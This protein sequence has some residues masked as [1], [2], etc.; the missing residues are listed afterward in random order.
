[1]DDLV[2]DERNPAGGG[3][4]SHS[5]LLFHIVG[6]G[7]DEFYACLEDYDRIEA[8]GNAP[9]GSEDG[10]T[11]SFMYCLP[12]VNVV[13]DVV[14]SAPT[15]KRLESVE[16]DIVQLEVVECICGYHMGIDATYLD[17]VGDFV[18]RC[19][20]CDREIDTSLVIPEDMEGVS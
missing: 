14:E 10:Y 13:E 20:S 1:L 17:Q 9:Y 19:P 12:H 3:D 2:G 18:T 16:N 6:L 5:D 11:E 15:M 8:R 4:D 7:K